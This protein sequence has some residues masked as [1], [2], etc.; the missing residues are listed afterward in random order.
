MKWVLHFA[1]VNDHRILDFPQRLWKEAENTKIAVVIGSF[2]IIT[3]NYMNG[4]NIRS[5]KLHTMT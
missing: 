5:I 4:D 1:S 2:D 3:E